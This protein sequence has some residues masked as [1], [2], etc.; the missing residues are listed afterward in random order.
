MAISAVIWFLVY[1]A[2]F[3]YVRKRLG[4]YAYVIFPA[5][6]GATILLQVALLMSFGVYDNTQANSNIMDLFI[7]AN[8]LVYVAMAIPD[9]W[10]TLMKTNNRENSDG[11]TDE[12]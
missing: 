9:V 2:F 10:I 8:G 11:S 5:A 4:L 3:F 1:L 7:L 12:R 6:P